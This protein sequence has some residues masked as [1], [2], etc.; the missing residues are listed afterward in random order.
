MMTGHASIF[1]HLHMRHTVDVQSNHSFMRE[2]RD[3]WDII[4][5][6]IYICIDYIV[7]IY[8]YI[9]TYGSFNG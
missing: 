3:L 2:L 9:M 7:E 6:Y 5:K 8:I 4:H 1:R